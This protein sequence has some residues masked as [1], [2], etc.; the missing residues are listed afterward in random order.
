MLAKFSRKSVTVGLLLSALAAACGGQSRAAGKRF[1]P[2]DAY[3]PY[4]QCPTYA[5]SIAEAAAEPRRSCVPTDV[6]TCGDFRF[7]RRGDGFVSDTE[8]F[9]AAGEL[10]AESYFSDNGGS[11]TFGAP[12]SC[13]QV[14]TTTYCD[15]P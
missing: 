10:V 13:V 3:C 15:G 14:V 12:P 5:A 4:T 2:L 9:N 11:A 7:V 6:G 8:F 1:R